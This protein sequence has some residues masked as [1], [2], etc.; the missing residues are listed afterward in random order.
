MCVRREKKNNIYKN[1]RRW[2]WT[3]EHRIDCIRAECFVSSSLIEIE[4]KR[5]FK[6]VPILFICKVQ[7]QFCRRRFI[8]S[9]RA[10]SMLSERCA[11]ARVYARE[12]VCN[13]LVQHRFGIKL[14]LITALFIWFQFY[15][16]VI[17]SCFD[18][19][20][21][22]H[23]HDT[24]RY[25]T[26]RG[27]QSVFDAHRTMVDEHEHGIWMRSSA[28]TTSRARITACWNQK[29]RSISRTAVDRKI[30]CA[31]KIYWEENKWF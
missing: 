21:C 2:R 29:H 26:R 3:D 16:M 8:R 24:H 6:S 22:I 4:S 5:E 20:V 7:T 18:F 19:G 30:K 13:L 17:Q 10:I 25:H 28:R 31:N 23:T 1:G 14:I 12:F 9:P 11:S 15:F 27:E